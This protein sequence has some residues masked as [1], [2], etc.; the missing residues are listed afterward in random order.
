SVPGRAAA[1]PATKV[2]LAAVETNVVD[3]QG[4]VGRGSSIAVGTDGFPIISYWDSGRDDLKVMHC[5][6]L[7]CTTATV[8]RLVRRGS[9]GQGV[10]SLAIGPD[11]MPGISFFEGVNE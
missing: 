9:P 11:G 3:D 8:T 10:S 1:D 4:A 6:S 5:D 7:D 2:R